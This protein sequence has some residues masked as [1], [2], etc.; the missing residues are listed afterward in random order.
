MVNDKNY[1]T[2][3]AFDCAAVDASPK[4][5]LKE[6]CERLYIKLIEIQN[7]V[8]RKH[9]EEVTK[10]RIGSSYI[11]GLLQA[12][13]SARY[14]HNIKEMKLEFD[15]TLDNDTIMMET[16]V[17]SRA[18]IYI[19]NEPETV[20]PIVQFNTSE[21]FLVFGQKTLERNKVVDEK[22]YEPFF[23]DLQELV[24]T[25]KLNESPKLY[26]KHPKVKIGI[27]RALIALENRKN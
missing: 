22:I 15:E 25:N 4:F 8:R 12:S 20:N 16:D 10:I 27:R 23:K 9:D 24:D 5:F 14:L 26:E 2:I 7:V 17:E 21:D 19:V 18:R 11:W 3:Y 1:S 13:T 6:Q